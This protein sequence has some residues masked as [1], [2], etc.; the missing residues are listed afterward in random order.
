M[1][2]VSVVNAVIARLNT[3]TTL[4]G[5]VTGGITQ[6]RG[7]LT[8]VSVDGGPYVVVVASSSQRNE[9]AQRSDGFEISLQVSVVDNQQFGLDR[10][11]PAVT[12]IYGNANKSIANAGV[13][14]YGLHMHPL[15][16]GIDAN[17]WKA[18]T[19]ICN[20]SE[21]DGGQS[22]TIV[23]TIYFTVHISRVPV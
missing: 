6:L 18:N 10:I 12:R 15:T 13:P 3:D 5:Y 7:P 21:F 11:Y 2:E 17:G 14:T 1:N 9:H 19:I 23:Q 20:G 4:T 22:E 16:L 8:G